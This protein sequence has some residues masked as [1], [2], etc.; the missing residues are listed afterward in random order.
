MYYIVLIITFLFMVYSI[1]NLIIGHV[2]KIS[3]KKIEHRFFLAILLSALLTALLWLGALNDNPFS[4]QNF[5]E[6]LG[7]FMG[8][9]FLGYIPLIIILFFKFT[10]NKSSSSS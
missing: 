7:F 5:M 10:R 9:S 4:N 1:Y 2:K 8:S 6:H 3:E